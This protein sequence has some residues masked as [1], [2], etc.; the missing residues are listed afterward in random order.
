MTQHKLESVVPAAANIADAFKFSDLPEQ[1]SQ[2]DITNATTIPTCDAIAQSVF[3]PSPVASTK[4][5]IAT[6]IANKFT[7]EEITAA[8]GEKLPTDPTKAGIAAAVPY[9]SRKNS[10]TAVALDPA[11]VCELFLEW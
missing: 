4:E 1:L 8:I 9:H 7:N 5:E 11:A 3:D 6:A 10:Q 2:E